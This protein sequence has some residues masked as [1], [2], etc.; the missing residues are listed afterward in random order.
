MTHWIKTTAFVAA[1]GVAAPIF[2]QDCPPV[3][4]RTFEKDILHREL[5]AAPRELQARAVSDQI[6][7]IWNTAPDVESQ[8]LLDLGREQIRFADYDSAVESLTDLI[9][10]CPH[11]AEGWNQRAFAHFLRQDYDASLEDI[12]TVLEIEP[13][14]FGAL[15]GRASILISMGRVDIGFKS[16]RSALRINPWL[17][18][19]HLLP[20]GED[21]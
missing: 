16:L 6:W 5:L 2:A 17:S 3:V 7:L 4:D 20:P 1:L 8:H 19:R 12:A 10:Y 11:F 14:H 13:R 9:E 21:I 18:E 15:A